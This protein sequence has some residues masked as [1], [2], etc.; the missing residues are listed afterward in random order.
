MKTLKTEEVL[1]HDYRDIE[2]ARAAINRF[3]E[4]VYNR[5]RLH[6]GLGYVSPITFEAQAAAPRPATTED[7][8]A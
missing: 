7:G 2:D 3:L 5:K 8:S 4:E 6:S 1:L